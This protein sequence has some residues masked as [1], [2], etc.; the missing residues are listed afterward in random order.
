MS[1]YE[2]RFQRSI[3][4]LTIPSWF[5]DITPSLNTLNN[6]K[7]SI[8]STTPIPWKTSYKEPQRTPEILYVRTPHSYRSCRSSIAT[9][10]SPSIHSWHPNFLFDGSR[11]QK[12]YEK[13]IERVS[14]SSRWYQPTQFIANETTDVQ[15]GN[16]KV[17]TSTK[18]KQQS[19]KN[20]HY[21][22]PKIHC[23]D[24]NLILKSNLL[25]T[26]GDI[27]KNIVTVQTKNMITNEKQQ[28]NHIKSNESQI[29]PLAITK[30]P[31]S[32][33]EL[34]VVTDEEHDNRSLSMNNN[35]P[36][37]SRT[38]LS[39]S[40]E[41]S[42]D[43]ELLERVANDLVESVLNNILLLQNLEHD[44]DKNS[45][46][47]E[48]SE[49]ENGLRELDE[50]DM[51]DTDEFIVFAT[52][53]ELSDDEQASNIPRCSLNKLYTFSKTHHNGIDNSKQKTS[54]QN[55]SPSSSST[56]EKDVIATN[57]QLNSNTEQSFDKLF[58][59]SPTCQSHNEQRQTT[60]DEY[61]D[62][63]LCPSA[64][65]HLPK[66]KSTEGVNEET[67]RI[68][69]LLLDSIPTSF[70]DDVHH[71][72]QTPISIQSTSNNNRFI[73]SDRT[74]I[75][76]SPRK[77][78][79]AIQQRIIEEYDEE[80][81]DEVHRD[82]AYSSNQE[83]IN[84]QQSFYELLSECYSGYSFIQS[85]FLIPNI[86]SLQST[87]DEAYESEPTTMSSSIGKTAYVHPD[88]EHEFEYPSPPPPVPDR[89]LKP[90]HLKSPT[91]NSRL[92]KQHNID[93]AEYSIIQKPK[94]LPLTAIQQLIVST[95]NN[96][97]I[98]ST[99]TMSSRH[100]CGSIPISDKL[101]QSC[102]DSIRVNAKEDS[103][104]KN[105]DKRNTGVLSCLHPST[106]DDNNNNNNNKRNIIRKSSPLNKM[107]IKKQ[108]LITD[109]DE[110]TNGLA[111]RLPAPIDNSYDLTSKQSLN[112]TSTPLTTKRVNG[113]IKD[114]CVT[115]NIKSDRTLFYETSV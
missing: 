66:Y 77:D 25:V 67:A 57:S 43:N 103:N 17:S 27:E 12:K 104:D 2:R 114:Q 86:S 6:S 62:V 15:T 39:L 89:R 100:Y 87:T 4:K 21:D 38:N 46:V 9:S 55:T 31:S 102:I 79:L 94:S 108:K 68:G 92:I 73:A 3:Q 112:R 26:N 83:R 34:E 35:N 91:I 93:S 32:R 61:V 74:D 23:N 78:C 105:K 90:G 97:N 49:D 107:K 33:I 36:I 8:I 42:D 20:N 30:E 10:P 5:T 48:L 56:L 65:S 28:D 37:P 75:Y 110:A 13:G 69:R 11:R 52:K 76:D 7:Q 45:G 101:I 70:I 1:D 40:I 72:F 113:I 19:S 95:S 80:L 41:K 58:S 53:A 84:M 106:T 51:N 82:S 16:I 96:A 115:D 18:H 64:N 88:L 63:I 44:D 24:Q 22:T 99:R 47:R 85:D 109:F 81:N 59:S 60:L 98:S 54:N 111:I 29:M 50:N 14:K 71:L